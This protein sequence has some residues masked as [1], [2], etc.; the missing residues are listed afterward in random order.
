[1]T[2]YM[3]VFPA[4]AGMSRRPR[5]CPHGSVRFPRVS[6]DEPTASSSP[7]TDTWFSPR[8]RG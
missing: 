7:P 5:P 8:E 6:G 3:I 2:T 1:M 4:S